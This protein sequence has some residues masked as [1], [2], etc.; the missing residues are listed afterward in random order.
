MEVRCSCGRRLSISKVNLD[1]AFDLEVE[2][3]SCEDCAE[4]A[5]NRSYNE[6][7]DDGKRDGINAV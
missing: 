7:Y 1:N 4:E 5:N 6:G 3:E 2:V